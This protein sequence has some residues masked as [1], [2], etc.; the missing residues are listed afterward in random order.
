MMQHK[1]RLN[2]RC[3]IGVEWLLLALSAIFISCGFDHV[4]E[5]EA[6]IMASISNIHTRA[7]ELVTGDDATI[8][9]V[10]IMVFMTNNGGIEKNVLFAKGADGFQ[11]PF[12]VCELIKGEKDVYIVANE[13]VGLGLDNI[14][15]KSELLAKLATEISV[16]IDGTKPIL[17]TGEATGQDLTTITAVTVTLT[18]VAAKISLQFRKETTADVK[19]TKVSLLN[20]TT[21]TTLYPET[22]VSS[23]SYWSWS[24]TLPA[25]QPLT[26]T[27]TPTAIS[28]QENIY[29]YENLTADATDK[30]HATRLEVE[31]LY[32]NNPTKYTVYINENITTP[33]G[34]PG[35]PESSVVDIADHLYKIKRNYHYQL[36]GTIKNMGEFDDG[37]VFTT[38]VLPWTHIHSHKEYRPFISYDLPVWT[39]SPPTATQTESAKLTFKMMHPIGG[40]WRATLTNGLDFKFKEGTPTTGTSDIDYTIEV[41][42]TKPAGTVSRATELYLTIEGKEVDPDRYEEMGAIENGPIGIGPGNRYVITQLPQ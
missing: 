26:L 2:L 17:M 3:W 35:E 19:I 9:K 6:C 7:G 32:D 40:V 30:T 5:G 24:H 39:P 15:S 18:R 20:N 41:V 12:E 13:T 34:V 4:V 25:A 23:Q 42:A 10:R 8:E 29:L 11:N 31:A 21:K 33:S 27:T 37:L 36:I 1:S 16:P 14:T 28:G 22:A 38:N